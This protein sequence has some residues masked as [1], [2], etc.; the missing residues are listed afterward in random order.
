[1]D[2]ILTAINDFFR[3]ILFSFAHSF[4]FIFDVV[5]EIVKRIATLDIS[6]V[7]YKWF[8]LII[9]L[10][11][12][13]LIF[14]AF[15]IMMKTMFDED[16]RARINISQMLIKLVLASFAIGFTPIAFSYVSE[17]TVDFI[18][19]VEY[20]VPTNSD[21]V[22]EL[23]PS[24]V[25][26][27]AGRI[28]ISDVNGDL[29]PEINVTDNFDVNAKDEND[30]YLYFATYTSLFL[31]VVESV[32]GCFIFL[33]ICIMIGQR[34]FSITY[35]YLLAPYPISGLIDH[36]DKSFATWMKMLLGDFM[37]NFAQIYGVYLT[38]ILCNNASIQ[39]MLG[40]DAVGICAKIIFFLAGLIAVLN[41][42]TV[43][44]T[45]I[46]GH[47][48][49]ALQSLQETKTI[50]TMSK[51]FTSGLAGAT[52]GVA[53]GGL[54]GAIGGVG[55]AYHDPSRNSKFGYAM[56]GVAGA[57]YGGA[58]TAKT[59]FTGGS[60]GGGMTAGARVFKAGFA[61]ARGN[62]TK[63][64][65]AQGKFGF[66]NQ[67]SEEIDRSSPAFSEPPTES[68]IN[69]A[70]QL[71][72]ENPESY[73]KGELS[74]MIQERGGEQSYWDGTEQG[75]TFKSKGV[76]QGDESIYT[77]RTTDHINNMT[78]EKIYGD[79]LKTRLHKSSVD[80]NSSTTKLNGKPLKK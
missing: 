7:L 19:H 20:F 1:M 3:D 30:N 48:A 41:L 28:N 33:L 8:V 57:V 9:I 36:E 26:L 31:L 35:K 78:G 32:A 4:L 37:M 44:S 42:P 64:S 50:L 24:T 73:S 69:Y 70:N 61:K 39:Q 76:K 75:E 74:M 63:D 56:S 11:G 49:G 62:P 16:Y 51:S 10:I 80:S 68:Q 77:S 21:I 46:G 43:I 17:L 71:G 23:K 55:G 22:N 58:T 5:W 34:L 18:N 12:L 29:G 60:M 67:A 40:N 13:F 79:T 6:G 15:K 38:I 59:N 14:R 52:A 25:L 66:V 72:I 54:G 2:G 45:I 65:P 27:E 53:I 47:G